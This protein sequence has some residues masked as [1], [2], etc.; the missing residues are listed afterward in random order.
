MIILNIGNKDTLN[1]LNAFIGLNK[2]LVIGGSL[3]LFLQGVDLKREVSDI[4]IIVEK[5]QKIK[6]PQGFELSMTNKSE[7]RNLMAQGYFNGIKVDF[8]LKDEDVTTIPLSTCFDITLVS[9]QT[10]I[11]AKL[12]YLMDSKT[13]EV[14]KKKHAKVIENLLL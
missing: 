5:G 13:T 9:K 10:I 12:S 14:E 7:Y 8:L 4:D 3:S 11:K 2:N 1:T 6:T